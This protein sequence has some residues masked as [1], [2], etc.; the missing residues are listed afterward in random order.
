MRTEID[1]AYTKLMYLGPLGQS[2]AH[3][4]V[5]RFLYNLHREEIHSLIGNL[6][7]GTNQPATVVKTSLKKDLHE[8]IVHRST[9]SGFT[10]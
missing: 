8:R 7:S 2:K 4:M 3:V 6:L 10:L 9:P 1:V 5:V